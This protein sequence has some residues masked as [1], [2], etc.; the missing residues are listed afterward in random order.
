MKQ[1][2]WFLLKCHRKTDILGIALKAKT[3]KTLTLTKRKKRNKDI[4]FQTNVNRVNGL[5]HFTLNSRLLVSLFLSF[6]ILSVFVSLSFSFYFPV[7]DDKFA[8]NSI[9]SYS[10]IG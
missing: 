3:E 2:N 5:L 7:L 4:Y 1:K 6:S 8:G 9:P 10:L